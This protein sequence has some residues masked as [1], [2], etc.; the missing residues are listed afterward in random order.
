LPR[1]FYNPL[2]I[3]TIVLNDFLNILSLWMRWQDANEIFLT[4]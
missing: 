4:M 1:Y 3:R 2:I